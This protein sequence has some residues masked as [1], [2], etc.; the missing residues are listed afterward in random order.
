[1]SRLLDIIDALPV[2]LAARLE[3]DPFF[4]DIPIVVYEEGNFTSEMQRKQALVTTKTGR[5]GAAVIIPQLVISDPYLDLQFGPCLLR[6]AFQVIEVPELNRD[7][8]GTQKSAR[9]IGRRIHDIIK[10]FGIQGLVATFIPDEPYMVPIHFAADVPA[11]TRGYECNFHVLESSGE[12][13][14]QVQRPTFEIVDGDTLALAS[15]TE[16][17]EIYYT[18]DESYPSKSNAQAHLYSSPIL[19]PDGGLTVRAC[20]YPSGTTNAGNGGE[21]IDPNL[22]SIIPSWVTRE[23]IEIVAA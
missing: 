21:P 12:K 3:S 7:T 4:I 14:S 5:R 18:T 10:I 8:N 9:R 23:E 2:E 13:M 19:I 17:A 20:A 11:G 1:M 6:P 15:A 22:L 16:G